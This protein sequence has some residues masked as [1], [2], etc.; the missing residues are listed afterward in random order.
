[1]KITPYLLW[2]NGF[3][4][5]AGRQQC[6]KRIEKS[7]L[8]GHT[9]DM[10]VEPACR[11]GLW[12]VRYRAQDTRCDC[13]LRSFQ[14]LMK[15]SEVLANNRDGYTDVNPIEIYVPH[16]YVENGWE[17]GSEDQDSFN[18]I[19]YMYIDDYPY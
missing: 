5:Y 7:P 11:G 12:L 8:S 6:W 16:T 9:I 14:D 2:L 19:L 13:Y 4:N 15:L 18:D 1:M 10:Q 17:R 3:E